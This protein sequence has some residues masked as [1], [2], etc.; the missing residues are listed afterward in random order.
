MKHLAEKVN[1]GA[2]DWIQVFKGYLVA[3]LW[4]VSAGFLLWCAYVAWDYLSH[5][6]FHTLEQ[7]I[8]RELPLGTSWQDAQA[9][10]RRNQFYHS[11]RLELLPLDKTAI[12][13]NPGGDKLKGKEDR[14]VYRIYGWGYVANW[15]PGLLC[16][17]GRA[18]VEFYFDEREKLVEY[19]AYEYGEGP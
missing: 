11:E 4:L 2:P 13:I 3:L 5:P 9:L 8:K 16:G 12:L 10:L 7:S 17:C 18:H 1:C 19:I 6:T 14:L 15:K